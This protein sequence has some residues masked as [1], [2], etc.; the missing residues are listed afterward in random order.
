MSRLAKTQRV[1]I[2]NLLVEGMSLRAASRVADVSINTVYKLMA[3]AGRACQAYHDATVRNVWAGQVQIDE[4]WAFCYAKEKR[5]AKA[6]AAPAVA[7]DIWTW[8][9]L[10]R[11]SKM[12]VAWRVG[13]RSAD[14]A[15]AFLRDLRRRLA[16]RPSIVTDGYNVYPQ[17]VRAVFGEDI[18]FHHLS[19]VYGEARETERR[20]REGLTTSHVERSNLT[21]RMGNRR[22]TR[23]TNAHSKK[24]ENHRLML[25]L[26]LTHYNF[27]RI[28]STIRCPPEPVN[29][30]ETVT[31]AIY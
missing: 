9:A 24:I 27:V 10:D 1:Q 22:Y 3:D 16:N 31:I 5:L 14:T 8:T 7:G 21:L 26:F 25:A 20:S 13:D 18:D 11:G 2:L 19:K 28:H 23:R 15:Y 6:V 12:M 30:F 17:A 29:D 4:M